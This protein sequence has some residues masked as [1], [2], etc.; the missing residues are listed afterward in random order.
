MDQT[1][2][3]HRLLKVFLPLLVIA[4]AVFALKMLGN[5]K[6]APERH[7]PVVQGTLVEVTEVF[8]A[9]HTLMVAAT[10]TVKAKRQITLTPQVSGRI[11]W[12]S[13]RLVAGGRFWK[14]D[15]LLRI[16]PDDYQLAIEQAKAEVAQAEVA[17]ATE[18]EQARVAR[19]EWDAVEFSGKGEPGPLVTRELQLKQQ[20]AVLA[21]ARASLNKAR[22]NLERT[23]IR[24]PFNG[25]IREEQVDLGQYLNTGSTIAVFA[26]TDYA[27]IHV[28]LGISDLRWL[29]IP[30]SAEEV[31]SRVTIRAPEYT[32]RTWSGQITRSLGEIDPDS[33]MATLVVT[34]KDPYRQTG[35]DSGPVLAQGLFVELDIEGATL[36]RVMKIPRQALRTG[37]VIWLANPENRL[38]TRKVD[39]IRRERDQV[40]IPDVIAPGERLILTSLPGVADGMLLRPV[41][42]EKP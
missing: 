2:K 26:G 5:L 42:A 39:V 23:E 11:S 34:V 9:S 4:V 3:K 15:L 31:G 28:P 13:N 33:R 41:V 12:L 40:I 18:Q 10:G 16:E 30:R 22:L 20:Q 38:A 1:T 24:A 29:K 35:T 32:D 25:R 8:P 36:D 37:D 7:P 17:L 6:P 19:A 27:E 14:G 21:A